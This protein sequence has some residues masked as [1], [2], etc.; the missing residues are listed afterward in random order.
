MTTK[1][2]VAPTV[3][4][5][6]IGNRNTTGCIVSA[7]EPILDYSTRNI[8]ELA[9]HVRYA[10]ASGLPGDPAGTSPLRRL[11]DPV[12]QQTNRNISCNRVPRP[13]P[14]GQQC[15]EYPFAATYQGG[16]ANGPARTYQ[17]SC[18]VAQPAWVDTLATNPVPF[19]SSTG[20]SMCLLSA[21]QN[22][23]AGGI[24]TWFYTKNRVLDNDTF[25]VKG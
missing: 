15:D 20:I 14:T 11:A 8:P 6:A 25:Y 3:R 16:G 7:A 23:R 1:A 21:S 12:A 17:G 24:L 18:D 5:D 4:C 19:K 2:G 9:T 10:Q 13:R 22:Q